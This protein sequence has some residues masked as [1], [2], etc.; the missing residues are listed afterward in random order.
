MR[1]SKPTRRLA[2]SYLNTRGNARFGG[3]R[4]S[5]IIFRSTAETQQYD[6]SLER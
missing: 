3:N 4:Q 2:V 1:D 5:V 6:L